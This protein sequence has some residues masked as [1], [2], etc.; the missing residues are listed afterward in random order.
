MEQE[1]EG[2][3]FFNELQK[4]ATMTNNENPSQSATERIALLIEKEL[5]EEIN[6]STNNQKIDC[7]SSCFNLTKDPIE[8]KSTQGYK[9]S[10]W[11]TTTFMLVLQGYLT[12]FPDIPSI[13]KDAIAY[14]MK[15]TPSSIGLYSLLCYIHLASQSEGIARLFDFLFEDGFASCCDAALYGVPIEDI[16][17]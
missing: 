10:Q 16:M 2:Y 5:L 14:I 3:K 9:K 4:L 12:R 11:V 7:A 17:A 6:E 15:F 13:H 8:A 1:G